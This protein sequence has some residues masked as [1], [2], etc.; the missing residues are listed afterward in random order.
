MTLAYV[1][2]DPG[3]Y[4]GI[5]INEWA[6]NKSNWKFFPLPVLEVK[7]G[8]FDLDIHSLIKLLDKEVPNN[9]LLTLAGLAVEEPPYIPL[10][11]G[12]AIRSL[13]KSYGEIRGITH[14]KYGN[15][16]ICPGAKVWQADVLPG[17]TKGKEASIAYVKTVYPDI[18]LPQ[19]PKEKKN[20]HDGIA[21]AICISDYAR[22]YA[23]G[24]GGVIG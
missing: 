24:R 16:V 14:A 9:D 15:R 23:I 17:K 20:L 11:G 4:G 8:R 18:Q 6:D 5:A 10:N 1:G 7:K 21:D 3:R 22:K 2:I 19:H 13:F 12:F